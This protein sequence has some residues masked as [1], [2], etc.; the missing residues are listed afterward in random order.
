VR[1]IPTNRDAC[2]SGSILFLAY[3]VIKSRHVRRRS[4]R[5]SLTGV[6]NAGRPVT[7]DHENH[8]TEEAQIAVLT[9]MVEDDRAE[10]RSLRQRYHD[11]AGKV[12]ALMHLGRQVEDLTRSVDGLKDEL[13]K[14]VR[15][16]SRDVAQD[17]MEQGMVRR[18]KLER[19]R[20][21]LKAQWIGL[22]ISFGALIVSLVYLFAR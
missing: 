17:V 22:G 10:I 15:D 11:L 8:L 16:S 4:A 14:I 5:S 12:S 9:Q 18:E 7:R 20:W 21:G 2:F 1:V 19:E 13:P 6:R 3:P